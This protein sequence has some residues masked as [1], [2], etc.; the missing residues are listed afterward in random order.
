M[1]PAAVA[2]FGRA[3]ENAPQNHDDIVSE[4]KPRIFCK[5]R[6]FRFRFHFG[7]FKFKNITLKFF[8]E[9]GAKLE[10][11]NGNRTFFYMPVLLAKDFD[12]SRRFNCRTKL[13]RRLRS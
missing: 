6:K 9:K 5:S 10:K 4:N 2:R 11:L 8:Q 1:L 13:Y 12:G 3:Q 7:K